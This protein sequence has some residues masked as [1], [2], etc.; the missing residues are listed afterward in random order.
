MDRV[1]PLT[2]KGASGKLPRVIQMPTESTAGGLVSHR[3]GPDAAR[4]NAPASPGN[5]GAMLL[6]AAIRGF[7]I[8]MTRFG[9]MTA[10]PLT[11]TAPRFAIAAPVLF[12]LIARQ[13]LPPGRASDKPLRVWG[14]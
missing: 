12:L 13:P 8:P 6:L 10:P 11:M 1:S 14:R 7:S 3:P 9:L 2:L 5:I 4:R